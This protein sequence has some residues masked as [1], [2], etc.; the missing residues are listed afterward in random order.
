MLKQGYILACQ[1]SLKSDITVELDK[2]QKAVEPMK[3]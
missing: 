2:D 3:M 1:S